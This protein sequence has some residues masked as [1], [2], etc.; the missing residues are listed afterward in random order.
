MQRLSTLGYHC[1]G[2]DINSEYV[3]RA[4]QKGLDV[5]VM[6]AKHLEF[7]HKSFDTIILFRYWNMLR[8]RRMYWKKPKELQGRMCSSPSRIVLSF[9][10]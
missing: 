1:V 2:V 4:K 7:S 3:D 10:G 5:R 6:D 8:G 9:I